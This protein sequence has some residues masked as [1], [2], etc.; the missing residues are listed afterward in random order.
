LEKQEAI[1][2]H[3]GMIKADNESLRGKVDKLPTSA[4]GF[5]SSVVEYLSQRL[6]PSNHDEGKD[7]LRRDLVAAI[8]DDHGTSGGINSSTFIVE[9]IV[10]IR[11]GMEMMNELL[12]L[13]NAGEQHSYIDLPERPGCPASSREEP[14]PFGNNCIRCLIQS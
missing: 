7:F 5:G 9:Y 11:A 10:E 4:E 1:L 13:S 12:V 8:Y 14:Y 3:L 6:S 2:Q